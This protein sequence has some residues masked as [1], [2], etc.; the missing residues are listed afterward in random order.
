[1]AAL[2][3]PR[4]ITSLLLIVFSNIFLVAVAGS[5]GGLHLFFAVLTATILTGITSWVF[6]FDG[7]RFHGEH[8]F[9]GSIGVLSILVLLHG[10]FGWS[11]GRLDLHAMLVTASQSLVPYL[12][13]FIGKKFSDNL[14]FD[15]SA[16]TLLFAV[17]TLF[18]TADLW[19]LS[20]GTP[21]PVVSL[22]VSAISSV[23]IFKFKLSEM[24]HL[25]LGV[26]RQEFIGAI[27]VIAATVSS[28]V[29]LKAFL[30]ESSTV[31]GLNWSIVLPFGWFTYVIPALF[32]EVIYRG[33]FMNWIVRVTGSF[34]F[35]LVVS[36]IM[37]GIFET[38]FLQSSNQIALF[39]GVFLGFFNGIAYQ[40]IGS[41][42]VPILANVGF[43]STLALL[44]L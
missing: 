7:F 25:P 19:V 2:T 24:F 31:K 26:S 21:L 13:V 15:F 20:N 37:F 4:N 35:G 5:I 27:F 22:L 10:F 1:M 30:G 33:V 14:L 32:S 11:Q 9:K 29:F 42:T 23:V 39:S 6:L 8:E 17:P 44:G 43:I 36:S 18:D 12:I 40:R 28:M 3:I 38:G 34:S 16:M 41:L